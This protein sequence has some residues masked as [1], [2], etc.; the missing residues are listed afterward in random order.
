MVDEEPF[1]MGE[2]DF[3]RI[4]GLFAQPGKVKFTLRMPRA[5]PFRCLEILGHALFLLRPGGQQEPD[6]SVVGREGEK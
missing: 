2:A 1:F 3:F 5:D 4:F 6:F